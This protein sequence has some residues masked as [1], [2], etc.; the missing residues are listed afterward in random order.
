MAINDYGDLNEIQLDALKEIGN[1]GSGNAATALSAM[2][3]REVNIAVPK[4][5]VLDYSSV[6]DTLGGPEQ[7][8]V[9]ILFGISG[10]ITGMIMFLLHKEF[11]HM[12][13]NSLVGSEFDGY[14]GLDEMDK[15]TIQEVG[16]IM[17]G[18][19][20]NA[21]AAMTGLT[22]DLSVPTMNVDMAGALLSVPAIYYA[23]ISDKIIVIEDE[24]GHEQV[25][26]SSH[27]LLIPEVDGL[28]KLMKSLGL[29]S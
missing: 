25:G 19:Y 16:N 24:F 15:S 23:N 28:T 3:E 6:C 9:G 18:S 4:I 1:I 7:L 29:D 5:N 20:V 27:V 8:L 21:M 22:I 26:A 12:V 10:D 17:A 13:L 2:L 14:S 11:A